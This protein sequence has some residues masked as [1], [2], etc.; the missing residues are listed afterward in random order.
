M[1]D[2]FALDPRLAADTAGIVDLSLSTVR[3]MRD[4]R[5]PWVVLIPRKPGLVE[6]TD[7]SRHDQI[8]LMDEIARVSTCLKTETGCLKLNVAAIGNIV[9]QLHVHVIARFEVDAAWPGPV[10]GK[11]PAMAYDAAQE[12]ALIA[13]LR[14][15]LG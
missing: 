7:L 5:Y 14:A 12:A 2:A 8:E 13:S 1:S 6:L 4:A 3:L 9:R 11:H 15:R 10:W